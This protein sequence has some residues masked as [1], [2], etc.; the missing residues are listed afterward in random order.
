MATQS[1]VRRIAL[2]LDGVT[3]DADEFRF[4]VDGKQFLWLW[5]ERL[6]PKKSRVPNPGVI[7]ARV[8]DDIAKQ[9]VLASDRGAFFTEPHY[10]GY[11]AVLIRLEKIRVPA[12]RERITESWSVVGKA[13]SRSR[14]DPRAGPAGRR[15]R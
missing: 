7:V 6:D 9:V 5:R 4:F 8:P 10:D 1:D 15:A 2:S 12:L 11:N 14:R 3:E 13:R